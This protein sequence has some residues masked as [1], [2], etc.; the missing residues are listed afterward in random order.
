MRHAFLASESVLPRGCQTPVLISDVR[1][2]S[3]RVLILTK[4]PTELIKGPK[5]SAGQLRRTRR[6]VPKVPRARA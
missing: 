2:I 1:C 5:A 6:T 3:V 4:V